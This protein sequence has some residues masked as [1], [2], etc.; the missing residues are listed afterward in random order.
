MKEDL[1][2]F[3]VGD[4]VRCYGLTLNAV[5]QWGNRGRIIDELSDE[6]YIV[7]TDKGMDF[8][9]PADLLELESP[10][11]PF[12]CCKCI[13][14][15]LCRSMF[16]G[17]GKLPC[18]FDDYFEAREESTGCIEGH[19]QAGANIQKCREFHTL[20]Y[21]LG[22]LKKID[23]ELWESCNLWVETDYNMGKASKWGHVISHIPV[24]SCIQGEI[25]DKC[26]HLKWHHDVCYNEETEKYVALVVPPEN[27]E[28]LDSVEADTAAKA[29]LIAYINAK[30]SLR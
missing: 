12:P 20:E 25:Q 10:K 22:E 15:E 27:E 21:L 13:H 2:K 6:R 8:A 19:S 18:D 9:I 26:K 5:E 1:S 11:R 24:E 17:A 16:G 4:R 29:I 30:E 7:R 28:W 3:K 14:F 23:P